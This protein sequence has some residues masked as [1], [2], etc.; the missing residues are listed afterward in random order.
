MKRTGRK[1]SSSRTKPISDVQF[2]AAVV[3]S[4]EERVSARVNL[5]IA[6][7][8]CRRWNQRRGDEWIAM[9]RRCTHHREVARDRS[10]A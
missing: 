1:R 4:I 7:C 10:A 6:P 3:R 9:I 5:R 8:G 2:A